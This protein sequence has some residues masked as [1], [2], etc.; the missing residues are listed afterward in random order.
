MDA[1]GDKVEIRFQEPMES[2]LKHT[3]LHTPRPSAKHTM[4]LLLVPQTLLGG[5]ISPANPNLHHF[6]RC[7]GVDSGKAL[8]L[9]PF[10]HRYGAFSSAD[11]LQKHR[12]GLENGD[13]DS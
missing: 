4:P 5:E 9:T 12:E 3:R 10:K 7:N 6:H 11:S 1:G 13:F 8:L 2:R